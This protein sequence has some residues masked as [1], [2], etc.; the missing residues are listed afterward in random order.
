MVTK[1]LLLL[2]IIIFVSTPSAKADWL[3]LAWVVYNYANDKTAYAYEKTVQYKNT[4]SSFKI[5]TE[6]LHQGLTNNS[7]DNSKAI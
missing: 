4:Y 5:F 3:D 2:V 6:L 7:I 1:P